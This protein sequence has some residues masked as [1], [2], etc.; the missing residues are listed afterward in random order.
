MNPEP[1]LFL[2][3]IIPSKS[4][5]FNSFNSDSLIKSEMIISPKISKIPNIVSKYNSKMSKKFLKNKRKIRMKAKSERFD[6]PHNTGQYLSHIY[7]EREKK[8]FRKKSND[9]SNNNLGISKFSNDFDNEESS[10]ELG[11][12]DFDFEF[13]N[14][15]KR[16]RL[17]S[18]EGKEL[19]DFLYQSKA[20]NSNNKENVVK[21]SLNFNMDMDEIKE[22]IHSES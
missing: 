18:M 20:S 16:D 8:K 4:F 14:D 12:C 11:N 15:K 1:K 17:M 9:I 6:T 3:D 19:V 7:Q 22:N 5:N 2:S 21:S 10:D 13:I